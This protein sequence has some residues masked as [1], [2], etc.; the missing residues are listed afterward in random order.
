M[1][2]QLLFIL[3]VSCTKLYA[4]ELGIDGK[5]GSVFTQYSLN[6]SILQISADE[7]VSVSYLFF[8]RRISYVAA[9]DPS[10]APLVTKHA[11]LLVKAS[12]L[13]SE[14]YLDIN[15][16]A[17]IDPGIGIEVGYQYILDTFQIHN[18][19]RKATYVWGVNAVLKMD[20]FRFY[21]MEKQQR[22]REHPFTYGINSNIGWYFRS[23]PTS[24]FR[25]TLAFNASFLRTWNEDALQSYQNKGDVIILDEIVALKDFDGRYGVMEDVNKLRMAVSFPMYYQRINPIPYVVL[26][27][28][29]DV[30]PQYHMGIFTN[31]LSSSLEI[32]KL[33]TKSSIGLGIDWAY[34]DSNLGNTSVVLKGT[35][36]L[37]NL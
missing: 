32:D 1:K 19:V 14:E 31:I 17:E 7:P 30:K 2:K 23:R 22:S 6:E 35:I 36:S 11:G 15:N 26:N 13:N 18:M 21:D 37:G 25:K 24:N 16:L 12:M 29:T 4:Q 10:A 34:K 27:Y 5:G 8:P 3:I 9:T 33:S 20:N 28:V